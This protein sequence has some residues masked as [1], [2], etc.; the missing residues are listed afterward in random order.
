M[1]R[2]GRRGFLLGYKNLFVDPGKVDIARSRRLPDRYLIVGRLFFEESLQLV[3]ADLFTQLEILDLAITRLP[4][5]TKNSSETAPSPDGTSRAGCPAGSFSPAPVAL[6]PTGNSAP[7]SRDFVSLLAPA[8]SSNSST[9]HISSV[10]CSA[11]GRPAGFLSASQEV[12]RPSPAALGPTPVRFRPV[13]P[14]IALQ[15]ASRNRFP[16]R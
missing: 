3:L 8:I 6:R 9:D 10:S 4:S 7:R 13:L 15:Q 16:P 1:S 12:S 2:C 14:R 5:L 11:T